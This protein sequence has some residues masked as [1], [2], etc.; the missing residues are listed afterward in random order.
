MYLIIL[1]EKITPRRKK[2]YF[3][4]FF[5][6]KDFKFFKFESVKNLKILFF[7]QIYP[8]RNVLLIMNIFKYNNDSYF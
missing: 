1:H 7:I 4:V 3:K 8:P 6:Q 2:K 5:P